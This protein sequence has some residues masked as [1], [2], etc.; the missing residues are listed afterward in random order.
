MHQSYT[1]HRHYVLTDI[2]SVL[3]KGGKDVDI[4]IN[5]DNYVEITCL[6]PF[7]QQEKQEEIAGWSC[8]FVIHYIMIITY[9]KFFDGAANR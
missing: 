2:Y 6:L 9:A 7:A 5:T 8:N 3:G 4:G 1:Q